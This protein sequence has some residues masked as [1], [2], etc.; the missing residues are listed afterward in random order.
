MTATVVPDHGEPVVTDGSGV[1]SDADVPATAVVAET[2]GGDG[3]GTGAGSPAA[4]PTA[5][6]DR[7]RDFAARR[8]WLLLL[9]ALAVGGLVRIAIA[10]TDD[11]A[12]T[13]ETAYLR[14]GMS[15]VNGDGYERDGH[16]ETHF[17]PLVPVILGLGSKV[18]DDPHSG[19]VVM[20]ALAATAM[21]LPLALLARRLAG[22]LAGTVTAWVAALT[23]GISTTLVNRGSG[24]EAVYAALVV[25]AV[26]FVVDSV[27]RTGRAR[28]VRVALGG[29]LLGLAYL[30]RPEGLFIAVPLGLGLAYVAARGVAGWRARARRVAAVGA[31]FAAPLA[32][33]ILP[34]AAYLHANTGSWELTAKTQDASIDAWHAVARADREARDSVLWA[35]DDTGYQFS[36]EH[37]PLTSLA[38]DDPVGYLG[39]VRTNIATLLDMAFT[40]GSLLP[41]LAWVVAAV[42]VWRYRSSR[43]VQLVLLVAAIPVATGLAFFV[44]ARYLV[45]LVAMM[46]VLTGVGVASMRGR[47]RMGAL[48]VVLAVGAM[49]VVQHFQGPG[50]WGQ[51]SEGLEQRAAADW[52]VAHSD[53]DDR[54]VTRSQIVQYYSDRTALALP[55]ADLSDVVRFARHHGARYLVMDHYTARVLRPQLWLLRFATEVDG[56]RLVYETTVEKRTVRVFELDPAAPPP[57]EGE[58]VPTL[59]F[60]GDV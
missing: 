21:L 19:T 36:V 7:A 42:G 38:L 24:S 48:A 12:S 17:P 60:T 29:A 6:G 32:L 22:P 45:V 53:A 8:F 27:G 13:D 35:L 31:V 14:S 3:E 30:T 57:P 11:Q 41:A 23:P 37:R 49:T 47:L 16:P 58:H 55:Y 28:L 25:G 5:T 18:F 1:E 56:L 59:G 43:R 26:W 51:P 40:E 44:Q 50:G 15:L 54:I 33:C 20:T 4:T 10:A 39:I 9:A 2:G 46:T 34:Y 52:I